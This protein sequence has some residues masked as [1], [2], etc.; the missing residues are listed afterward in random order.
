[1]GAE[2]HPASLDLR[3]LGLAAPRA[4]SGDPGDLSR[5]G[6]DAVAFLLG[7]FFLE[8]GMSVKKILALLHFLV[9]F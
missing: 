7:A 2:F 6:P 9:A 4:W 8:K 1:M 5:P 3:K